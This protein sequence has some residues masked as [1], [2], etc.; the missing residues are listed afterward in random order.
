M[1]CSSDLAKD[2][3]NISFIFGGKRVFSIVILIFSAFLV[4]R[5]V[6]IYY[7]LYMVFEKVVISNFSLFKNPLDCPTEIISQI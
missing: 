3:K 1:I 6:K 7:D 2:G 4:V 5:I